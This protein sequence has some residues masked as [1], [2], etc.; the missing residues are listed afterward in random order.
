LTAAP[1]IVRR[2][3]DR[4]PSGI[5]AK[6][7][8]RQPGNWYRDLITNTMT[9]DPLAEAIYD[10]ADIFVKTTLLESRG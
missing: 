2:G 8:N 3:V 10:Q 6:R 5:Q 1:G 9:I 7:N 4:G